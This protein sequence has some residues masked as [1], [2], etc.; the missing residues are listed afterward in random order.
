MTFHDRH[1]AGRRLAAMLAH[2]AA[3]KPVVLASPRGG[4]PVG[5][6][7]A[8]SLDAPLDV[9]VARRLV[10]GCQH[11]LDLGA[12]AEGGIAY[13]DS[14]IC[15]QMGISSVEMQRIARHAIVEVEALSRLLA[16]VRP[17][18]D[19]ADARV[20]VTDDGIASGGTARAAIRAAR[21]KGARHSFGHTCYP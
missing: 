4:M 11:D 17:R 1:E 21:K 18:L 16:S 12:V 8:R 2:H 19:L 3:E 10:A 9:L 7:V 13:V 5:F 14:K 20:I 6:E 15:A